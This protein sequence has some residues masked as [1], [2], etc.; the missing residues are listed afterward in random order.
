MDPEGIE[1]WR[2][3]LR[4]LVW[5]PPHNEAHV[6]QNDRL[7]KQAVFISYLFLIKSLI[8]A[9]AHAVSAVQAF[10]AGAVPDGDMAT[11]VTGR[12]IALQGG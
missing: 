12:R 8:L 4:V 9:T 10:V 1:P 3:N 2:R 5:E 7:L 6:F 11:N